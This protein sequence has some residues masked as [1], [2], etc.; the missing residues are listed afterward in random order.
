MQIDVAINNRVPDL[1]YKGLF[2]IDRLYPVLANYDEDLKR[3][4]TKFKES[5]RAA[6]EWEQTQIYAPGFNVSTD[7]LKINKPAPVELTAFLDSLEPL[8]PF[9][10]KTVGKESLNKYRNF[11]SQADFYGDVSIIESL[12]EEQKKA[13]VALTY[14]KDVRNLDSR[15]ENLPTQ[16]SANDTTP[17]T[18]F[19]KQRQ[20]LRTYDPY[21]HIVTG[22][23]KLNDQLPSFNV[24]YQRV[25]AQ[26]CKAGQTEFE[27]PKIVDSVVVQLE[28][29]TDII[30]PS[31]APEMPP[32]PLVPPIK[33]SDT[34]PTTTTSSAA[35]TTS[36]SKPS[37][38]AAT[39]TSAKPSKPAPTT[40]SSKPS[41]PSKPAPTTSSSKP[42]K[43]GKPA[44]TTSTSK[45][46]KPAPT[47]SSSKPSKPNKPAPTTSTS[48]PS[49]PVPTTTSAKPSKPSKPTEAKPSTGLDTGAIIGIVIAV[50]AALGGIGA[51]LLQFVPNLRHMLRF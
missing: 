25:F 19:A 43:P 34:V 27:I 30:L 44:P 8:Y 29:R 31:T 22:F 37:K 3:N 47:T 50:L 35:P 32:A 9:L 2:K 16:V 24:G 11:K 38:P 13:L 7:T 51:A 45:P 42:S 1:E 15:A 20:V 23:E 36:S 14:L 26:A 40:S 18:Y 28:N 10:E 33:P 12:T 21:G 39:T 46:S 6:L 41:K 17:S 49:K 5:F 48:K 4:Q